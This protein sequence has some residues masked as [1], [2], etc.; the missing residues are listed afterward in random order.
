ME[1][2]PINSNHNLWTKTIVSLR[3]LSTPTVTGVVLNRVMGMLITQYQQT[4]SHTN[5]TKRDRQY[6]P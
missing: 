5:L 2:T 3:E 1:K 4:A 6:K